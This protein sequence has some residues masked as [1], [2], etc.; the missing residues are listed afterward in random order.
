LDENGVRIKGLPE[1]PVKNE[2]MTHWIESLEKSA[3]EVGRNSACLGLMGGGG[4]GGETRLKMGRTGLLYNL[5]KNKKGSHQKAVREIKGHDRQ[6]ALNTVQARGETEIA[7]EL[8]VVGDY[9]YVVCR[10]NRRTCHS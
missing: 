8:A 3:A 4:R 1:Q 5:I 9:N 2:S 7:L 10:L 6:M